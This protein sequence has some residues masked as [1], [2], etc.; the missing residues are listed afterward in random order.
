M[1][2]AQHI[3]NRCLSG[4][5]ARDRTVILVTHHISLCLPIA[6]YLV[7][8][9]HGRIL[10]RGS[11]SSLREM[12]LLQQAIDS[13]DL[14]LEDDKEEAVD[15]TENE[16]DQLSKPLARRPLSNGKLIEAEARAEGR[17]S[18][19][20]YLIYIWAAGIFCWILTVLLMLLIRL[21]NI[22]NQACGLPLA[23]SYRKA[24]EMRIGFPGRVG[25]S[26]RESIPCSSH[27]FRPTLPMEWSSFTGFKRDAMV[28]DFSLHIDRWCFLCSFIHRARV[29]RQPASIPITLQCST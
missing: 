6:N 3:V 18:L 28:D 16:M 11:I 26:L 9:S 19:R 2:T 5:L 20:T 25:S 17:V 10:R 22:A 27:D 15:S 24:H 8:L 12:G 14:A 13:E 7:E 29:L 21:I 1:H 23:C 4:E